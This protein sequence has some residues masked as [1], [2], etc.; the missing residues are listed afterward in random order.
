MVD[1][2]VSSSEDKRL[3]ANVSICATGHIS[4]IINANYCIKTIQPNI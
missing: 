1:S 3:P 2:P 4:L